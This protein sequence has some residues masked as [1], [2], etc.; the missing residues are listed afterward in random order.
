MDGQALQAH[1]FMVGVPLAGTLA[2]VQICSMQ[3]MNLVHPFM[4][5]VPLA[6]TLPAGTLPGLGAKMLIQKVKMKDQV[7]TWSS[8]FFM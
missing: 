4:V 6:G 5:G 2:W 1:P 3:K 7:F 8:I